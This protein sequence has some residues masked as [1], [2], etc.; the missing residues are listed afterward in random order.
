M[1][2]INNNKNVFAVSWHFTNVFN[3]KLNAVYRWEYIGNQLLAG[4]VTGAS[5]LDR[6]IGNKNVTN[7]NS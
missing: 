4:R 3:I 6:K 2:Y 1:N 7:D 5:R